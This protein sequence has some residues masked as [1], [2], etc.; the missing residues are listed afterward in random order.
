M[1][2][3]KKTTKTDKSDAALPAGAVEDA[4]AVEAAAQDP[5]PAMP[6]AVP[7]PRHSADGVLLNPEDFRVSADGVLVPKVG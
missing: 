2:E 1:A 7:V 5:A 4:P 3:A 6:V